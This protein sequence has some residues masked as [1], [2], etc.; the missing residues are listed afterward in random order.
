MNW[1]LHILIND[2]KNA[3]GKFFSYTQLSPG[4]NYKILKSNIEN[5]IYFDI[6]ETHDRYISM[7]K[8]VKITY[9]VD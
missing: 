3:V 9:E 7:F 4:E 1:Q 6:F 5:E 8:I 2:R